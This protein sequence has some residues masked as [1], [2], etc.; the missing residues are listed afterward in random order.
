MTEQD[1]D[2]QNDTEDK[3]AAA[4][5]KDIGMEADQNDAAN[6]SDETE[7]D[8]IT[9]LQDEVAD[10]KE[11][12]MRAMAETENVRRRAERDKEDAGHYAIAKFARDVLDIADNLGRTMQFANDDMKADE[13]FKPLL[14]GV[15]MNERQLLSMLERHGIKKIEP[16][17]GDKF[18]HNLHQAMFKA[19]NPEVEKNCI[20]QVVS[21]GYIIK[22]RL[23]RAA[24]VGVSEG[25]AEPAVDQSV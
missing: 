13:T 19:P 8:P 25:G 20:M 18:D 6:T 14:E 23:L 24:M 16:Q 7:K 2:R 10:L 3:A 11:R 22:D 12:L 17:M 9:A 21:P 4:A 15:E 5:A 1:Q